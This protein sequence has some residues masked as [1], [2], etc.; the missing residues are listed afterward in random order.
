MH[1]DI[2]LALES[3]QEYGLPLPLTSLTQ[4]MFRAAIAD[5]YG[6]LDMCST[7]RVME[8]WAG[9]EVKA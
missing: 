2:G 7:I 4:Q 3:A 1:K 5:G 9:I 8:R 6:E